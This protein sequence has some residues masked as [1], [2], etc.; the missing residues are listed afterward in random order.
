VPVLAIPGGDLG[1]RDPTFSGTDWSFQELAGLRWE[2]LQV[3]D[4]QGNA[5]PV[6]GQGH[7]VSVMGKHAVESKN[8]QV[9]K[10]AVAQLFSEELL[11]FLESASLSL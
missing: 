11:P 4:S 3:S 6:I 8:V 10:D 9:K 7:K 1:D 5:R 2:G